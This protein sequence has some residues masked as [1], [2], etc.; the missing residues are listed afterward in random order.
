M[1][2]QI[3][4]AALA[5]IRNGIVFTDLCFDDVFYCQ[6]RK[7]FQAD[8]W[9]MRSEISVGT[10]NLIDLRLSLGRK[11]LLAGIQSELDASGREFTTYPGNFR[12]EEV[13]IETDRPGVF[14]GTLESFV[15]CREEGTVYTGA[16][17]MFG[18]L[19][20]FTNRGE[21]A[22]SGFLLLASVDGTLINAEELFDVIFSSF[23]ATEIKKEAYEEAIDQ[24]SIG[25]KLARLEE[26][27]IAQAA[28]THRS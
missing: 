8:G 13:Q 25:F 17:G 5:P 15:Q 9:L 19:Y 12:L 27:R 11:T 18:D 1:E 3:K 7:D 16:S 24:T 6:Y 28:S 4:Y 26:L 23:D 10:E 22:P 20:V 2:N 14:L 21:D